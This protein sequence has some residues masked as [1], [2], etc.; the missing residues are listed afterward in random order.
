MLRY[1]RLH[2]VRHDRATELILIMKR[3][4]FFGI[5]SRRFCRSS[6]IELF[7]FS[8]FSTIGQGIL[9]LP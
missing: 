7:N 5:S 9:G 2:R 4:S 6:T 1:M 3:T 8:F